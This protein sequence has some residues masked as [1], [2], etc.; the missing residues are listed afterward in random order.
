MSTYALLTAGLAAFAPL[1]SAYTTPVGDSPSGNAIYEPG[2]N[3]V[4]TAGKAF[5]IT[6]EPTTNGSIS[7]LLCKGPS[8]NCVITSTLADSIENSGS[9]SWTPSTDLAP[10]QP[11]GYG[12]ELVVEGTGEYQCASTLSTQNLDTRG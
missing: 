3:S 6:W 9:Y 12:I 1:A 2:L 7:L 5:T 10:S 8:T 11:T 4:V